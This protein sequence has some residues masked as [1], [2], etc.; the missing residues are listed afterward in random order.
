M[1][2]LAQPPSPIVILSA[3]KDLLC[4]S[5]ISGRGRVASGFRGF[6]SSRQNAHTLVILSAAKDLLCFSENSGGGR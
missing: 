5:Q 1:N 3:A 2:R 6:S 4:F